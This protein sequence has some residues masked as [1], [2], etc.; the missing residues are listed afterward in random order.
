LKES[1]AL[2]IDQ[3]LIKDDKVYLLSKRYAMI[4][5]QLRNIDRLVTFENKLEMLVDIYGDKGNV[6]FF[7]SST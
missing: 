2:A 4:M 3:P 6:E 1:D 7:I 5:L